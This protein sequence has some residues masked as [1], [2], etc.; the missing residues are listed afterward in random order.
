MGGWRTD[1]WTAMVGGRVTNQRTGGWMSGELYG[2]L[3][4]KLSH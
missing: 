4:I 1:G 3:W 2:G